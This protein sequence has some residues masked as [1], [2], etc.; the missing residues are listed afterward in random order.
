[1]VETTTGDSSVTFRVYDHS[2][3]AGTCDKKWAEHRKQTLVIS[4]T[5]TKP[6]I[7]HKE[8][9]P[10]IAQNRGIKIPVLKE[11]GRAHV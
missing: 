2:L 5:N 7:T 1:M 9:F 11:I 8:H 10:P 3:N 6:Q 4:K